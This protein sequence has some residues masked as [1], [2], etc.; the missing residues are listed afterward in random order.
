LATT[1]TLPTLAKSAQ[2]RQAGSDLHFGSIFVTV[3]TALALGIHG[4]HPYAEDG[5]LYMAGV[6]RLLNPAL[7]P[8][9]SEFVTAHLRFSLFAPLVAGLARAVRLP[10][11]TVWLSLYLATF[12][13]TLFAAWLLSTRCYLCRE[14]RCGAV[15]L[16]TVWLTIPIAGTSLMLMDPYFSARSISTPCA[17]FALVAILDLLL[18]QT[19][20]GL[21]PARG[22]TIALLCGSLAVAAVVHPLMSAYALGCTLLLGCL[23]S[24]NRRIRRGGTVALS[25]LALVVATL[26][27]YR[28]PPESAAYLRVALTRTYWFVAQWRWYEQFGL[29]APLAILAAISLQRA[30]SSHRAARALARTA[31]VAGS[32][33]LVV[34]LPF[35]RASAP[36]YAVARLQPLRVFQIVYILMILGVGATLGER[37][38]QRRKAHW[39]IT[40]TLLAAIMVLADRQTFPRSAHLELPW[41]QTG[42]SWQRAFE[43]ISRNTPVDAL[44]ALDAHYVT[45]PGEDAQTFRAIAERSALADYSKDGGETSI[46]PGLTAAWSIGQTAQTGLNSASD[47]Q[48]VAKLRPLGVGWIVLPASATTAFACDFADDAVK[49]CRLP[50]K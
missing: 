41:R 4:Y 3:L 10:L 32:V 25:L 49:V 14:A 8:Y 40:F 12:W 31:L 36:T 44:F 34:A 22:K 13:L 1:L 21:R 5:G 35:A 37:V 39:A 50:Q 33:A 19:S 7:Y 2:E 47:A 9:W 20:A 23:L 48:R 29:A 42:N 15:A 30:S 16:L 46:S 6:K 18:P 26:V 43:W 28:S 38:L 45:Q 17:L 27:Y 24:P 11:M